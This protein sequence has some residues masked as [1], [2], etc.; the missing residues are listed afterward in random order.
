MKFNPGNPQATPDGVKAAMDA[1][2]E[3]PLGWARGELG[4]TISTRGAISNYAAA[5]KAIGCG[6]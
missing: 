5:R 1:H 2:P 6:N 4:D 3:N